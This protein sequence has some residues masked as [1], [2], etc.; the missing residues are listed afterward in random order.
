MPLGFHY[1]L[2]TNR[3]S[4]THYY[5]VHGWD[6]L[7]WQQAWPQLLDDTRLILEASDI[8]LSGPTEDNAPITAPI[9]DEKEG[10]FIN[11]VA[12]D[13]HEPFILPGHGFVKTVRKP[14]DLVVA[15]VLLR[16]FR[17]AP[18]CIEV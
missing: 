14:Y 5:T 12:D 11:G 16:A 18:S 2:M 9:V 3:L 6:M 8:L 4:Y 13:S 1:W 15:C 7:E 10:I 17:L